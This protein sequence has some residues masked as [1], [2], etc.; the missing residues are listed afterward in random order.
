M[1]YKEISAFLA[2]QMKNLKD[3]SDSKEEGEVLLAMADYLLDLV[4]K[5]PQ[6]FF[7]EDKLRL[8]KTFLRVSNLSESLFEL[9]EEHEEVFLVLSERIAA[10]IRE[11]LKGFEE[12]R[13]KRTALEEELKQLKAESKTYVKDMEKLSERIGK[14]KA[15]KEELDAYFDENGSLKEAIRAEGCDTHKEMI[16]KLDEMEKQGQ[17][18]MNSYDELLRNLLEEGEKLKKKIKERQRK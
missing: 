18:L 17:S 7:E 12:E 14:A 16:K 2:N 11:N 13:K 8:R 15:V 3:A 10:G 9:Y 6:V 1:D 5:D 4:R